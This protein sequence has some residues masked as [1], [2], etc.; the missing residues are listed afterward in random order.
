MRSYKVKLEN[1]VT[2][3]FEPYIIKNPEY[4]YIP[5]L[6]KA[7][8]ITPNKY[9]EVDYKRFRKEKKKF[10]KNIDDFMLSVFL[11][12]NNLD[13]AKAMKEYETME[14]LKKEYKNE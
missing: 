2:F 5:K 10:Y 13:M 4:L 11:L 7:W 9:L 14:E 3:G 1:M 8:L 12:Y 6:K